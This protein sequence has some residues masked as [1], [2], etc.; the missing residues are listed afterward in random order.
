[1]ISPRPNTPMATT[2]ETDAVGQLRKPEAC[3]RATPEL[4]SVPTSPSSRPKMIMPSAWSSEPWA[5][6]IEATRPEHHEREI[7]GRAELQRHLG[8]RR[9]E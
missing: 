4:T 6:T 3:K 5:S 8:K 1:M 7:L 2:H 9:S